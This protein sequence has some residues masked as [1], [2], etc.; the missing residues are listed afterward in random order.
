[1]TFDSGSLSSA[2]RA[3]RD[4]I[5]AKGDTPVLFDCVR[6]RGPE[7]IQFDVWY[8]NTHLPALTGEYR[9]HR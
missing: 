9:M 5:M 1:V 3:M 2:T 6:A 7:G 8:C 4:A